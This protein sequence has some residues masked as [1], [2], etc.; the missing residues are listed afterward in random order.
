ME[1]ARSI[2]SLSED[3]IY[4]LSG[5]TGGLMERRNGSLTCSQRP[6]RPRGDEGP[7]IHEMVPVPFCGCAG[8]TVQPYGPRADSRSRVAALTGFSGTRRDGEL[9]RAAFTHDR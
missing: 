7:Y 5:V 4:D 9:A 1:L 8:L 2:T 3:T 6:L